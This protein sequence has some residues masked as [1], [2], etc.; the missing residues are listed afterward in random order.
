MPALSV[1]LQP[2]RV[3]EIEGTDREQVLRALAEAVDAPHGD[4]E[5]LLTALREREALSSTG[6]GNGVAM[7]H[8]RLA[9]TRKFHVVLARARPGGDFDAIDGEPVRLFML[10]VGPEQERDAYAKLMSRAAKF[11][12]AEAGGL[13]DAADFPA[14]VTAALTHY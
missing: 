12:K 9:S 6:F 8:A 3:I 1:L 5:A 7:P 14:A 11:L 10:V 13:I 2:E 4:V